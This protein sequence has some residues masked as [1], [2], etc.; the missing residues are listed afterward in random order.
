[1]FPVGDV[2]IDIC[3]KKIFRDNQLLTPYLDGYL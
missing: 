3:W 1:M 2:G